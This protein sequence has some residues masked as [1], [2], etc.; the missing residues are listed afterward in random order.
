MPPPV[1]LDEMIRQQDDVGT[2]LPQ[3]RH[4]NRK[5]VEAIVEIGPEPTHFHVPLEGTVGGGHDADIGL[6]DRAAPDP[7]EFPLL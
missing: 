3:R 1:F 4:M 7:L 6:Q 2:A 5:H